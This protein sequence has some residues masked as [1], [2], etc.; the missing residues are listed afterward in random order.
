MLGMHNGGFT[1]IQAT[2]SVCAARVL[3][4]RQVFGRKDRLTVGESEW[5]YRDIKGQKR[6]KEGKKY[7]EGKK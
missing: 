1:Q 3:D 4:S 5:R 2:P 7:K 6:R